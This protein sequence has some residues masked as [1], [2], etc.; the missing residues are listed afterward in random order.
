MNS[1]TSL[2]YYLRAWAS[3]RGFFGRGKSSLLSPRDFLDFLFEDMPA[4][5]H[6]SVADYVQH[7]IIN[8]S[9]K[10]S[11]PKSSALGARPFPEDEANDLQQLLETLRNRPIRDL[12]PL[13]PYFVH[14]Q[15]MFSCS[16]L[17]GG[18]WLSMIEERL[19]GVPEIGTASTHLW[20]NRLVS[21]SQDTKASCYEASYVLGTQDPTVIDNAMQKLKQRV[22]KDKDH[23]SQECFFNHQVKTASEF[24][25]VF[26]YVF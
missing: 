25:L 12:M 9:K 7:F 1:L 6:L 24:D 22:E 19:V 10:N 20:P 26:R 23:D 2:S 11:D 5:K 16:G 15:V 8:F 14:I 18:Q 17:K 21:E 13:Y 4:D 3:V